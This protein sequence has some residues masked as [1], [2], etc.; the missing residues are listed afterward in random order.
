[1]VLL[2]AAVAAWAAATSTT[3]CGIGFGVSASQIRKFTERGDRFS[4]AIA[5]FLLHPAQ[6]LKALH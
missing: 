4:R 1:M 5:P 2:L 3:N 6:R